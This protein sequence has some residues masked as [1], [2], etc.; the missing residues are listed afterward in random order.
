MW[1]T[2]HPPALLRLLRQGSSRFTLEFAA[3]VALSGV[4]NA[5][6][7]AIINGAADQAANA[8]ANGRYLAFFL[9]VISTFIVAQ[10]YMLTTTVTEVERILHEIRTRLSGEIRRASLLGLERIG[11]ADIYASLHRET[12]TISQATSTIMVACQSAIMVVFSMAYLAWLSRPAFVLTLL[13]AGLAIV[14]HFRR[15]DVSLD[16]LRRSNAKENQFFSAVSH[17][18]D[19]FKEIKLHEPRGRAVGRALTHISSDLRELKTQTGTSFASHFIFG[20]ASIY[21]LL[22]TIV[23]LLPTFGGTFSDVVIKATASVL[24]I[25]GPLSG[26]LASVPIMSAA[27]VSAES[28]FTLEQR[29]N[30]IATERENGQTPVRA[31]S[32]PIVFDQA[33]FEYPAAAGATTFAVGPLSLSIAPGEIVFIVG[34]N[35]SGKSTLLRMLTGLYPV[36]YGRL[37]V[38]G[39]SV[40]GDQVQAHRALFSAVF[41]DYHLFDQLYGLEDTPVERVEQLLREMELDHKVQLDEHGQFSTLDLSNGQKKRL[42]LIVALLEDRPVLVFDEWAADQDPGFRKHFYESIL[43]GLRRE[44]R[45]II[46]A[47]HDDRY[48]SVADRV[49]K[50]EYGQLVPA[51]KE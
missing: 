33:R 18:L 49:I 10:R 8:T 41:S 38:N 16:L 9:V 19:G 43:P 36:Q 46:A 12:V 37:S 48:F 32:G 23:F 22:G 24:F 2:V 14:M 27:N 45:T 34:G 21:L 25:V 30:E 50:L 35:G 40:T 29:L 28:I 17:V 5:G 1:L 26:L 4:A 20:Q 11:R 31:L 7:L 3:I 44:G 13:V 15:A 51:V 47:T 42:A 6:L 39:E